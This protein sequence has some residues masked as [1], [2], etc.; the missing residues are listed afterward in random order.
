VCGAASPAPAQGFDRERASCAHCGSTVRLRGLV[1]LISMEIFGVP[2]TLDEMPVMKS[3]RGIGMSDPPA[4]AER[5]AE[6]FDYTNTFYHQAPRFDVVSMDERH[7][8]Q[9]DFI[10]SSE[11][12]E[13][14]PPPVDRAFA[15]LHRMLKPDGV[16]LLTVPYSLKPSTAEHFPELHDF[17]V[18]QVGGRPVLV[19]RTREGRVEVFEN[20]VFHGGDGSTVEIR[21]FTESSLLALLK[22]AGFE[23]VVIRG[24]NVAAHG[25]VHGERWSLPVAARKGRFAP[26]LAEIAG[27]YRDRGAEVAAL[28]A[29]LARLA[30][31]LTQTRATAAAIQERASAEVAET[32]RWAKK[33]ESEFEERT[34][35]AVQLQSEVKEQIGNVRHLQQEVEAQAARARDL[36]AELVRVR[37]RLWNRVG[38]LL[39]LGS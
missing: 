33:I 25:V 9:Y 38:R 29:E 5:L 27:A 11:V 37:S 28:R 21:E 32:S 20:L 2:L 1:S 14:V 31:E 7:L 18:V 3:L 6:K 22:D 26:G 30:D 12:L 23:Q 10:V 34:R 17:R 15:T 16:L 13:H 24:E 39:R 36:E 19:N 35:W 4:L 8:G